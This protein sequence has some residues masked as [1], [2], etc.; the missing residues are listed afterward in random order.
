MLGTAAVKNHTK[1]VFCN[2]TKAPRPAPGWYLE[3]IGSTGGAFLIIQ[4][5][6]QGRKVVFMLPN[7]IVPSVSAAAPTAAVCVM[8]LLG[9]LASDARHGAAAQGR[10][11]AQYVA[12]VSGVPVGAGNWVVEI[13][14][15]AYTAAAS[16][17]TAGLL[18]FFTTAR[19]TGTAHGA[20][21]A[22]HPVPTSYSSTIIDSRHIDQVRMVLAN[23]NVIDYTAEPPLIPMPDR[24][25]VT[26]ADRR[27][28]VDPMTSALT[29]VDGTGDPIGPAAC[30]RKVSVFDGRVRYDLESAFKRVESVKAEKGYQGAAVVCALYFRPISGYVPD[31]A[32]IKY[33]IALR[34][35]EVWLVPIAGTR[36]LVPFR[37]TIPTPLGLGVLQA[38]QFISVAQ[39]TRTL[40][41]TQ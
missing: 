38:R 33:L 14:A 37:F 6:G 21:T 35:A 24:I 32:A 26:D 8:T 41:K 39:P 34:D 15:N 11:D 30:N 10:L 5:A 28:V 1:D 2:K 19:G 17:A 25:P 29:H 3:V 16:G 9:A 13:S 36:V 40:A 31:R 27:G 12:T 18:K 22:G 23:G 4:A 20:I 7:W